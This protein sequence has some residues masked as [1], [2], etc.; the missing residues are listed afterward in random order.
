MGIAIGVAALGKSIWNYAA[1]RGR[2]AQ[3]L[4]EGNSNSVP[5]SNPKQRDLLNKWLGSKQQMEEKGTAM[6]GAGTKTP[7]RDSPRLAKEYGGS[8]S[9]Y[10]KMKS[11][12][13][14]APD[15]QTFRTQWVENVKTRERFEFKVKLQE[16][17][18]K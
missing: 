16:A 4:L 13:H 12:V 1:S 14:T 8:A 17:P 7:F 3:G 6:A 18:N 2:S 10:A 5:A 11:S 9:D 15:G